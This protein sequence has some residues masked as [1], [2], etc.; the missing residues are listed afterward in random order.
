M[1][2]FPYFAVLTMALPFAAQAKPLTFA[3]AL[4]EAQANAPA[5]RAKAFAVEAAQSA[6]DAA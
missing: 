3:A 1:M 4:S 5:L 2:K 6:V